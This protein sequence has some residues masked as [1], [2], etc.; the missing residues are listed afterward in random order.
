MGEFSLGSLDLFFHTAV[1]PVRNKK[2]LE[3][4]IYW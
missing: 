4:D 2:E 1:N 3:K